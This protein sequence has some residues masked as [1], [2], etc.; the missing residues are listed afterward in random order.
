MKKTIK[1]HITTIHSQSERNYSHQP[2]SL[3][4]GSV[5]G[6]GNMGLEWNFI[7]I[8]I[9]KTML[10]IAEGCEITGQQKRNEKTILVFIDDT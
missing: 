3:V 2:K 7:S 1:Y 10:K 9:L 4:R 5:Q 8:L 6:S